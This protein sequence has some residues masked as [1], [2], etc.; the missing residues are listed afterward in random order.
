MVLKVGIV[1][2]VLVLLNLQISQDNAIIPEGTI[3]FN[4]NIYKAY[5]FTLHS[6]LKREPIVKGM[7]PSDIQYGLK[8]GNYGVTLLHH[9]LSSNAHCNQLVM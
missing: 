7:S 5:M 9:Y 2:F 6:N 4:K 3:Q 8:I 1:V